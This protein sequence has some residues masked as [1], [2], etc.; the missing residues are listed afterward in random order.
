MTKILAGK[1]SDVPPG[2][3]HKISLDK[4]PAKINDLKSYKVT[5][6]SDDIFVEV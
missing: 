6:E 5:V 1:V 2:K 3:M 4:F